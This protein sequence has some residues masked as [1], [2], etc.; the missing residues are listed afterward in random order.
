MRDD[1]GD[2]GRYIEVNHHGFLMIQ[3]VILD[4]IL[5]ILTP[6]AQTIYLRIFRQTLGYRDKDGA[7]KQ[8]D[9]I[10]HSQFKKWCHIKATNTVKSA[11]GFLEGLE[12]IEVK[13][14]GVRKPSR[15]KINTDEI[16]NYRD[17][18]YEH[19]YIIK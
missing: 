3:N 1:F 14:V 13:F 5:P 16:E 10:A 6:N 18:E 15:Y 7:S 2:D 12:L 17:D 11:V 8:W 19:P 9:S 4:R